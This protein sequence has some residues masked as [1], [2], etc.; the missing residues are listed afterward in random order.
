MDKIEGLQDDLFAVE[1]DL[2]G[3][4]L[5]EVLERWHSQGWIRGLDLAL[6]RMLAE[7]DRAAPA[8]LILAAVFC[9]HQLGRGH[10]CLDLDA[11]LSDPDAAL[12][13]P[14]EG[15]YGEQ[16]PDRPSELL[17]G[18]TLNAWLDSLSGSALVQQGAGNSP[19]VLHQG[20]PS[21]LYL[22]RQ[23]HYEIAVAE[24]IRQRLLLTGETAPSGL[25]A[26]LDLLFPG[27]DPETMDWQRLACALGARG[28]FGI[29]TG[30][31]G[32]GKT[33][34]V[35]RLLALL[36][37]Q[38]RDE[39]RTLRIRLAA[40][41]GKA[42]ARLTESISRAVN[43]L[44][45][46][47]NKDVPTE[48]S[49]LHRLLVSRPDSRRFR[50][51]AGNPLHADLVVVDE[52]SMIDLEMM[53]S[54]LQALPAQARLILLG[55]K[56]QLASVEAGAVLGDL[57]Q[58]AQQGGYSKGSLEWAVAAGC[59]GL[60]SWQQREGEAG[61][62]PLAQQIVMLRHSHRFGA[63]SGIGR[64]A[65]AVNEG[66]S[67]AVETILLG[68]SAEL[69]LLEP[70]GDQQRQLKPLLLDGGV[71]GRRRGAPGY[72]AYLEQLHASKPNA[73]ELT[74]P[75]WERWGKE[76]LEAFS[77]F[78]I[79][80]ALRKGPWGVEGQNES[81][82]QALAGA[83]L[84]VPDTLWYEGRP[85]ILTRNDY[86]LGLMNG[87]IGICLAV[88]DGEGG[89]V[90]RVV[91][92]LPDSSLKWVLPSR[93]QN[94]ETVFAMTVHKSQGSE[95]AHTAMVLPPGPNPVLT[96]ELI[97]T[98]ITRA[99]DCFTL[100]LPS[101]ARLYEAVAT[102]VHRASALRERILEH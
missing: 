31:P 71:L 9:S 81:I 101:R 95:F 10:I 25:A 88:P 15:A 47:M 79:L 51:H 16:L 22:R 78:R 32:T 48:V 28:R 98:G 60:G 63:D 55:D 94:V 3:A 82:E 96:R 33:T 34:T 50:H 93:L 91:F 37:T 85:V 89:K 65:R 19:L 87:D 43:S 102:R 61:E 6:A 45:D 41:T 58:Q 66:D 69:A 21:R 5:W 11:T 35:V 92:P 64:L 8:E 90:L 39:G 57:C 2:S 13:L 56:D 59:P 23:W 46:G 73:G 27:S 12:S 30:G 36:Q 72:R 24:F 83:G 4:R 14:P 100:V 99:S 75:A 49:T 54:L 97:Y 20:R 17:G 68:G 44:P 42:A 67:T 70:G 53:H 38:A 29:I 80:C 18:L 7:L 84:I 40:P 86:S 1:A 62:Q 74:D 76:V 26:K 52:A 77:Q